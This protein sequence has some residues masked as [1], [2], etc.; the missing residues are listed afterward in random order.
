[1]LWPGDERT[2]GIL[3][4][5][6]ARLDLPHYLPQY[7]ASFAAIIDAA[8][9]DGLC[10]IVLVATDE[11][12]LL[13]EA[14][15]HASSKKHWR[16]IFLLDSI[17]PTAVLAI[18]EQLDFVRTLFVFANKSGKQIETHSLFLYF[19]D[20]LKAQGAADPGRCFV[21]VTEDGSYLA[22]YASCY[23]FRALLLDLPDI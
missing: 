16:R 3:T 18:D 15:L 13:T 19:L 11:S 21:A 14:A 22:D 1:L 17:D 10:H 5:N 23:G 12:N 7:M 9:R 20:R 4:A 6:L 2:P 8:H